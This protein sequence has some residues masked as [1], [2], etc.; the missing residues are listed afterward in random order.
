MVSSE[1]RASNGFPL[2]ACPALG[3]ILFATV[4]VEGRRA[5]LPKEP[6]GDEGDCEEHKRPETQHSK[7]RP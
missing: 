3:V 6:V 7:A 1:S 5:V 4:A 2:L